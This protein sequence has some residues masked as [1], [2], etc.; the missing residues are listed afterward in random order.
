MQVLAAQLG[1][2]DWQS[3]KVAMYALFTHSV[4]NQD[5]QPALNLWLPSP[6]TNC[7]AA[8]SIYVQT[9]HTTFVREIN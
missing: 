9:R 3:M 6:L 4:L 5:L 8:L 1:I 2:A 7:P